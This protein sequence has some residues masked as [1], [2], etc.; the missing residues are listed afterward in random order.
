MSNYS[1]QYT[2]FF[3]NS[4]S[5]VAE[6]ETIEVSHPSFSKNYF[7]VR[8]MTGGLTALLENGVSQL[9][10]YYPA[11]I[12]RQGSNTTLDQKLQID[13]GDLGMVIPFELD[14]IA[15]ANTFKTKPTVV[16]RSYRSDNLGAPMY[17]PVT[18]LSDNIAFTKAGSTIT[19]SAPQ[20]NTAETGELYTIDRFPMLNGLL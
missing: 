17:G 18:F 13:L 11:R 1:A 7:F 6:L 14:R 16:F 5:V 3:F 2:G 12:T 10:Q 8:N 15:A 19:A 9:F 20:L 4:F